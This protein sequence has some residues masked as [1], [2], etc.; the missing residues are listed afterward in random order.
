MKLFTAHTREGDKV[1]VH[2][3]YPRDFFRIYGRDRAIVIY[4]P[5]GEE[6]DRIPVGETILCDSC[7]ALLHPLPKEER[8]F[9]IDRS[10]VLC[11]HCF[12]EF[13]LVPAYVN[14]H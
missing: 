8:F 4:T 13:F 14:V 2:Q 6:V 9:L 1:L 10:Y 11:R 3:M 7:N 5:E 12:Q